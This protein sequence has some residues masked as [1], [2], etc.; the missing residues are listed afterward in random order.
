MLFLYQFVIVNM[1]MPR[2]LSDSLGLH[3]LLVFAAILLSVKVAGFWGAFFGIPVVGVLW[4]MGMFFF[5]EYKKE[6]ETEAQL[7]ENT[8]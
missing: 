6:R 4:A 8:D 7:K 3:P 1:L 5:D 2:V